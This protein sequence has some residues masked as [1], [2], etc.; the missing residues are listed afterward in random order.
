MISPIF[1]TLLD[2]HVLITAE[3]EGAEHLMTV[4]EG[5][6]Q[7]FEYGQVFV[8]QRVLGL[9]ADTGMNDLVLLHFGQ[10]LVAELDGFFRSLGVTE[11]QAKTESDLWRILINICATKLALNCP[12]SVCLSVEQLTGRW[13]LIQ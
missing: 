5:Q 1:R 9:A 2:H 11:D 13:S 8:E 4:W 3:G 7:V 10:F 12:I 6:F